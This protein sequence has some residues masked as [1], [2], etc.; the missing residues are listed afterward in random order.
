MASRT[1]R[2]S[3]R[4][5][6]GNVSFP[7][8]DSAHHHQE[9]PL[10]RRVQDLGPF[11]D[12][13]PQTPH[14]PAQPVWDRQAD[15]LHQHRAGRGGG[16]HHRRRVDPCQVFNKELRKRKNCFVFYLKSVFFHI[17]WQEKSNRNILSSD[18]VHSSVLLINRLL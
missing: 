8:S 16:G 15:H 14:R 3:E 6:D 7:S 9:D 2:T 5:N 17:E 12:E 13:D 4:L 1:H 10:R 11:P 18:E